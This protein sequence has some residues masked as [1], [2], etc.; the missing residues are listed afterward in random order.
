MTPA[1]CRRLGIVASVAVLAVAASR[2]LVAAEPT[3]PDPVL[4]AAAAFYEGIRVETLPNGL[5]VFLKPIPGSP[6]VSTMMA[7]KVGSA[8]EELDATGLSHYLE[9][10]MFKGTEKLMPGDIDRLT[11]RSGGRN[12]AYTT[13]DMTV[14]HF[15]FAADQ[16]ETG[17]NIEADRMRNLRID[18]KHEFEQEKGAVISE[19][20]MN[21][22]Q[23]YDLEYK[24]IL[25][26]LFG[27][28]TPY[29][30]SV[31]GEREHVRGATAAVIKGHYDRW[32]FPNNASLIVCGGFDEAKAL[33]KIKELFGPIPKGELPARKTAPPAE[34]RAKPVKKEMPSKFDVPRMIMGFNA[35][36]QGDPDYYPLEVASA[37][38]SNGRTSRLYRK[39]VEETNV[40]SEIACGLNTGRYPGWFAVQ[41]ELIKGQ[42]RDKAE[43][44]VLDE[45]KKLA[46]EP[47]SE[48]ELKRVQRAMLSGAVFGRE[49]VHDLA[50]SIARGVTVNDLD[51][52]KNYLV[53]INAVTAA[54]VQ[55][56]AKKYLDANK[57]VVV[58]SVPQPGGGGAEKPP[59]QVG[60][61]PTALRGHGGARM[62]TALRGHGT[63]TSR[64]AD[65]GSSAFS[66]KGTKRVQRPNGLT[67]LLL[68]NHRLPLVTV[69]AYVRNVRLTEPARMAGV[70]SL[71]GSLLDE[72]TATRTGRQ[73]ATTIED[74]GGS[75]TFGASGGSVRV[76]AP[77]RALGLELL[78][79]CLTRPSFPSDAL[80]RKR[81]QTLSAIDDAEK[82]ADSQAQRKFAETIYGSNHPMGRP[83]IGKR[84]IVEKLTGHDCRSFHGAR[85]LPNLTVLAI[86][87]DF[88]SQKV[89]D[90]VTKLT[91]HWKA[92]TPITP[93][94][95]AVEKPAEFKQ[96]VLTMPQAEQLYFFLGHPGIRR[97]NPDYYKLLVMD[98]VL[99]TGPGFTDRLSAQLRDREGL[100]YSV[101][102]AIT[103][104][105]GEQPGTF[106]CYISTFPDK[107]AAVKQG[108]LK[109]L[110]RIR[111]EPPTA[112]EVED[113]KKYLLGSV[114]FRFTTNDAVASQL[115]L[116]ERFHLGFGY[117]DD[118][119]S[120][121]AAVT[122][123][124]VLAVARK[125]IDPERMVLV[126]AGAVTP[127]GKP[128]ARPKE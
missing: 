68:E 9:H 106:T 2:F 89:I 36:R 91:A 26:L 79:D 126:A 88:D 95:P 42:D 25:P 33:A 83:A 81:A 102:A 39:L 72:G 69:D 109:E 43:Q 101:S 51:Y 128:V 86:V 46:S 75:L 23:P 61:M 17:L 124:D 18:S 29:G 96:T 52:L 123:A 37:V 24:E 97:D 6:T 99:G 60:G 127:D 44:L 115:L 58:W 85:F 20:Q 38:L 56:V 48:A 7:Y 117:I 19:L 125:Y 32:Y 15:D 21:E 67:L 71:V 82:R 66:L 120:A 114:A 50:D 73:I 47:S 112:Q 8:D 14:Y 40:A 55:A 16:W 34:P 70:A 12:N 41:M 54:D 28:T 3:K 90:E 30:H 104:T 11:Q 22:D 5:R 27:K 10:L 49:S 74:V 108:F 119:K 113:A 76:L 63:Q 92:Q 57:R 65:A 78:I 31:I 1:T 84:P 116:V 80:E 4:R 87:G 53:K 98:N 103:S 13:E 118:Y 35:V 105:A 111:A 94:L 121:V 107:F 62:P 59:E 100:A 45:F 93:E 77:D 110:R 122:P 64:T